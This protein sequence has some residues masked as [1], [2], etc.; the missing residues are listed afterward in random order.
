[1]V[2][3]MVKFE[4]MADGDKLVQQA[5]TESQSLG[6]LF[7]LYYDRI[8]RF[9]LYRLFYKETAED[10]TSSIFLTVVHKIKNF[11]GTTEADFRNWLYSIAA[12]HANSYL[13]KKLRRKKL[14]EEAADSL[15]D[16]SDIRPDEPDWAALYCSISK[17]KPL[18]QTIVT[19]RFF[20]NMDYEQ[21][22]KVVNIKASTVRVALHRILER[23]KHLQ[24]M[25][26]G[27][28]ENV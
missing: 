28:N 9:C 10:V 17:L 21:I 13:R 1:M 19:L 24:E 23:L 27:E 7:D 14:L 16:K 8:Y 18:H 26:N 25:Q 4:E 12:N 5:K 22:G 15:A 20:E 11:Q 3:T 2:G 6:R